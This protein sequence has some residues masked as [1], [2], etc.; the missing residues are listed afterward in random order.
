MLTLYRYG[1]IEQDG[2]TYAH[3]GFKHQLQQEPECSWVFGVAVRPAVQFQRAGKNRLNFVVRVRLLLFV[4]GAI[5]CH[6]IR[7]RFG[8]PAAPEGVAE[9]AAEFGS[10]G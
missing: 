3:P 1:W 5:G 6:P 9:E 7:E 10:S 2:V 8:D 4:Y